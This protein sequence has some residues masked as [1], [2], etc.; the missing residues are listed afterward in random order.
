[1]NKSLRISR[2]QLGTIGAVC[3]IVGI[4][5]LLNIGSP[6]PSQEDVV[7]SQIP[8]PIEELLESFPLSDDQNFQTPDIQKYIPLTLPTPSGTILDHNISLQ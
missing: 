4:R 1:M 7:P 8:Q 6:E 2:L 3:C 5:I